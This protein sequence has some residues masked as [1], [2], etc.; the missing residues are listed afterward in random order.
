MQGRL[1]ALS[2]KY[3]IYLVPNFINMFYVSLDSHRNMLYH[4]INNILRN[5]GTF[6]W[7]VPNQKNYFSSY[8]FWT[9]IFQ[10]IINWEAHNFEYQ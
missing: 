8:N 5:A 10:L 9:G 6:K 3:D 2:S 4:D 7:R 1:A